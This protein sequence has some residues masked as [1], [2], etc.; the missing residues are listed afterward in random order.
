MDYLALK[1]LAQQLFQGDSEALQLND[2]A[3]LV[4]AQPEVGTTV[5]C[6]GKESD[7]YAFLSVL[8]LHVHQVCL[9]TSIPSFRSLIH[10]YNSRIA[11][12]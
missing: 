4:L 10:A 6:D 11:P 9:Y 1:R 2:L 12:S 8:N 5:K 3:D 7:P